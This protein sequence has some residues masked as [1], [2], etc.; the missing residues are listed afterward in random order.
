MDT[1]KKI[2]KAAVT[3]FARK[4]QHG[5][6]MEEIAAMAEINKAMLYYYYS[7]KENLYN[8]TLI[9]LAGE[10]YLKIKGDLEIIISEEEDP[11]IKLE[12]FINVHY[13]AFSSN[14]DFTDII[15]KAFAS[16]PDE[17]KDLLGNVFMRIKENLK[18]V[19][20]LF[21]EGVAQG[22]LREMDFRQFMVSVIGMN[23]IYFMAKPITDILFDMNA[24]EEKAFL[25]TRSDNITD[26]IFN[27]IL[28]R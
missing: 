9:Y 26:L 10:I 2:I 20:S 24:K 25:K 3:V 8:E 23:M 11:R 13:K 4:G 1:R 18:I 17:I 22:L 6:R 14:Q 28:K 19:E 7:T 27:G 12:K 21:R 16:N 5:A 15:I